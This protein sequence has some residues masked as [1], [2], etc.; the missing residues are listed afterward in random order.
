MWKKPTF[1]ASDA[2]P[3]LSST[4]AAGAGHSGVLTDT[5]AVSLSE[6]QHCAHVVGGLG[7]DN[8]MKGMGN[9]NKGTDNDRIRY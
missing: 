9:R 2:P 4:C 1:S 7:A 6:R 3:G 8:K 5:H